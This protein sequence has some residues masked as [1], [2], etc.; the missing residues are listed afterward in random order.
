MANSGSKP[1]IGGFRIS[2]NAPVTLAFVGLCTVATLLGTLSGGAIPR[3]VFTTYFSS[4][5]D[6]MFY[7]R[8]FTHIFG[9]ASWSHFAGNAVYL[10]LLGPLLEEKYGAAG[11]LNIA[12]G[13]HVVSIACFVTVG[14]MLGLGGWYFVGV[15]IAALALVYQHAIVKAGD[16]REVT[17][18]Y[19]MR[20]G[21]VSIA[22][23]IFTWLS[24]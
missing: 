14:L 13:L 17:Q 18:A 11:A 20:N 3:A 22:I 24:Y 7:V 8:L 5:L 19:F 15:A 6:P 10:L 2:L 9:H 12:R 21:I 4:L 16:Y 23:F 1:T